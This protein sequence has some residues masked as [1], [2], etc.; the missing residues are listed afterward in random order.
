ME[1]PVSVDATGRVAVVTG[2]TGGIG[3]EIA[4]GLSRLGATVIIGAR[5]P[6]RGDATR[7]AIVA[8]T[9]DADR[10]HVLPL[11]VADLGSVRAFAEDFRQHFAGLHVLV[12]NAGAWFTEHRESPD[13]IELTFATNVLGPHLLT[14]LLTDTLQH[15][16]NARIVNIVSPIVGDYDAEDLQFQSRPYDGFK[17]Y[18]QSKQA[19]SMLTWGA[20]ARLDP[21]RVTANAAVPGFVRTDLNRNAHGLRAAMINVFA[22]LIAVAPAKGADTPLWAALSPELDR[23]TGKLIA[24]RQVSDG[25]FHNPTA[26]ADL[27]R[28]CAALEQAPA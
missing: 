20:A 15:G 24:K 10:V 4:L 9:G 1:Q 11:D 5:N 26:I 13:G 28:R 18:K 19:L 25:K 27:E 3:R 16:G 22:R 12:N 2:A 7:E 23:V 17:A 14:E 8:E 6:D 21:A